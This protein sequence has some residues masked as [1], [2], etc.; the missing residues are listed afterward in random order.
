MVGQRN[1]TPSS[2]QKQAGNIS[3]EPG[4]AS[5]TRC[6]QQEQG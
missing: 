5:S 6:P 4:I 1:W 3:Y 2:S